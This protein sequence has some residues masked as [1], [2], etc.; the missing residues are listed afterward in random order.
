MKEET[1]KLFS[2]WLVPSR[3]DEIYLS[4]VIKKLSAEYNDP[5]FIPHL[6]LLG[7]TKLSFD[8][9]KSAVDEV[10]ENKK[11]FTI[12]QTGLNQSE[13]FFKTVF[14]EFELN[15][16]L[17]NLFLELSRKTDNIALETFK[18]HISLIYKLITRNEKTRIIKNLEVKDSFTID[19]V[20]IV[21]PKKGD[22]DFLNIESW[23]ILYKKTLA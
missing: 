13:H 8:D 1:N 7:G 14:I 4:G 9:L 10:F 3:K 23:R 19:H 20:F 5:I 12:K 17:K 16:T 2:V 11:P 18:P 6:T 22:A 21:A 15:N